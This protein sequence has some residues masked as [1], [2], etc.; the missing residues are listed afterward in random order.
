M[1]DGR[2]AVTKGK[3][4]T[5]ALRE[6]LEVV[7]RHRL[8]FLWVVVLLVGA[9][10]AG[11]AWLWGASGGPDAE[12][13]SSVGT[14]SVVPTPVPVVFEVIENFGMALPGRRLEQRPESV[15]PPWHGT[16]AVIYDTRR[17]RTIDLGPGSGVQF[18]PDSKYAAWLRGPA[19]GPPAY[20]VQ[21]DAWIIS[22][23]TG[24]QRALGPTESVRFPDSERVALGTVVDSKTEWK[25]F[26]ID[27][28][29]PSAD[30]TT[31]GETPGERETSTGHILKSTPKPGT[32]LPRGGHGTTHFELLDA[33][34]RHLIMEF[35][36]YRVVDAT[37][38][39][40]VVASAWTEI[41]TEPF[42][43]QYVNLHYLDVTTGQGKLFAFAQASTPNWPLSANESHVL[44][45]NSFCGPENQTQVII[46]DRVGGMPFGILRDSS[47]DSAERPGP[48]SDQAYMVL[49]PT[50]LIAEG[51]FG[52]DALIDP[53]TMKYV[54]VLPAVQLVEE[55]RNKGPVQ[56]T[57]SADYRYASY[58]QG[59]GHGG[60]C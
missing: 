31:P 50:G 8:P 45:T 57:W 33:D 4:E 48:G 22:L 19:P 42:L 49:T 39:E 56:P 12:T 2:S 27:T 51:S 35:D 13:R 54:A 1:E 52:A 15:F 43:S 32:E 59:G 14:E 3:K 58:W 20:P 9:C 37:A 11:L 53:V 24:A 28:L 40:L 47:G 44:W 29:Q 16:N 26:D 6:P 17:G 38:T 18:S 25:L 36:A 5:F 10:A 46:V 60:L 55:L 41:P 7:M 34:D 23:E 30:Q 21:G